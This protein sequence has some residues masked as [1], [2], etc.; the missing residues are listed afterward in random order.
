MERMADWKSAVDPTTGK[1]YWYHRKTRESRWTKPQFIEEM[2]AIQPISEPVK[3][4]KA[5]YPQSTSTA[6]PS[7]AS[8]PVA[9]GLTM[10]R[11]IYRFYSG[12][13]K[14]EQLGLGKLFNAIGDKSFERS[15]FLDTSII[16]DLSSY[17]ISTAD[18]E[19][20]WQALRCLWRIAMYR[21]ISSRAMQQNS[22][23]K[24]LAAYITQWTHPAVKILIIAFFSC[25]IIGDTTDS[26]PDED[27]AILC[28]ESKAMYLGSDKFSTNEQGLLNRT[29][30]DLSKQ[31]LFFSSEQGKKGHVLPSYLLL[32]LSKYYLFS[33]SPLNRVL[34]S[35]IAAC[36]QRV[37]VAHQ[38]F[39]ESV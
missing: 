23:W 36:L 33:P 10:D 34:A 24:G 3:V 16:S 2:E 13:M 7:R 22:S 31:S 18:N 20:R 4:S 38:V 15:L 12:D 8:Q 1:S 5:S 21:H 28:G 19:L 17:I 9:K 26:I 29:L 6:Q 14:V 30:E 37:Y 27:Y 11:D 39:E 32:L 35:N 25:I